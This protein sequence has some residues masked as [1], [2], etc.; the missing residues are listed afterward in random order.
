MSPDTK[1]HSELAGSVYQSF[2]EK[3]YGIKSCKIK[4][5]M[6]Y[7]SDLL[8]LYNRSLELDDCIS[9]FSNC[10]K[11]SSLKLEEKINTL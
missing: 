6:Y 11:C 10:I 5:D 7:L 3:K 4:L 8:F 2:K 1:I 9:I